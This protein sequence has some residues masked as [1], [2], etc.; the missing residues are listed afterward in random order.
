MAVTAV[1]FD[2]GEPP[3]D[4]TGARRCYAD[5]AGMPGFTSMALVRSTIT[6]GESLL[7][8]LDELPEALP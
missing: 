2:G 4:E 3:I 8:S 5:A 1:V 7:R 6:R